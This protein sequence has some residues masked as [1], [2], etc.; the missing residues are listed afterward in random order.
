MSQKDDERK[1]YE[2]K[3][4]LALSKIHWLEKIDTELIERTLLYQ[5]EL[6]LRIKDRVKEILPLDIH[7]V[8]SNYDSF[9][10][11]T[12]SSL[13]YLS[14]LLNELD[15]ENKKFAFHYGVRCDE[16][17]EE[18]ENE[19]DKEKEKKEQ[20]EEEQSK[21]YNDT[22]VPDCNNESESSMGELRE[23]QQKI[24][25]AK[26]NIVG[27]EE[28][29]K[30]VGELLFKH[31]VTADSPNYIKSPAFL[32]G[33]SGCGKTYTVEV[34]AKAVGLPVVLV[35]C[36]TITENGMKGTNISAE[37]ETAYKNLNVEEKI[38]FRKAIIIFDE[39]DKAQDRVNGDPRFN[40]MDNLMPYF[41]KDVVNGIDISNAQI[42]VTGSCA[43]LKQ[44]K[45]KKESKILGF[46]GS[47]EKRAETTGSLSEEDFLEY[48]YSNEII[49]RI[50]TFV[51]IEPLTKSDF[52]KIITQSKDSVFVKNKEDFKNTYGAE[53][54]ITD[55]AID[56]VVEEAEKRQIG[57]RAVNNILSVGLLNGEFWALTN[58]EGVKKVVVDFSDSK[59]LYA[60]HVAEKETPETENSEPKESENII[61]YDIS[62][63]VA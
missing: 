4:D 22:F 61:E 17:E 49:G 50:G 63:G 27:Q 1:N 58:V 46:G 62:G 51:E 28:A 33:P 8:G 9:D 21:K 52:K 15:E 41:N 40:I 39:F 44:K 54:E 3:I 32:Y 60:Y 56:F 42:F 55:R 19:E 29:K 14:A 37:I 57:A 30:V 53:L 45:A 5:N 16:E 25:N 24:E 36:S 20:E 59:G 18:E 11:A 10:I 35:N 31:C 26:L 34:L 48:G 7:S 47:V 38:K 23:I 12:D 13:G 43:K 2:K 6:L